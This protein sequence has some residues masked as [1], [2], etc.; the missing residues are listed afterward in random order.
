MTHLQNKTIFQIESYKHDGTLHRKWLKNYIL[1]YNDELLI[2]MNN[3]TPVIEA[4]EKQWM[5]EEP[6][7][8]YFHKKHWFNVIY[9][10]HEQRP[11]FYCN[12]SSPF[13][14]CNN[15]L[16]Y[17]DYDLDLIVQ[18]D[19]SYQLVDEDELL[20]NKQKLNY[21]E[22]IERNIEEGVKVLKRWV[23][24]RKGPFQDEFITKWWKRAHHIS[25]NK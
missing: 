13:T 19:Y 21:S 1:Y 3:R 2:G 23:E 24:K 7:L 6:V 5:T 18:N 9:I 15:T 25:F 12:I 8:F 22:E 14:Y 10:F 11:Y 16:S 4:N 20:L 17:I